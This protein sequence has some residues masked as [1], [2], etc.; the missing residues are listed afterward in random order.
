MIVTNERFVGFLGNLRGWILYIAGLIM[1]GIRAVLC[2]LVPSLRSSNGILYVVK[3]E[4]GVFYAMQ[5]ARLLTRATTRPIR[6]ASPRRFRRVD[7]EFVFIDV[8]KALFCRWDV[9]IFPHH[10]LGVL[11]DPDIP[12]VYISHGLESGK[13]MEQ[14]TSYT[15]GFKAMGRPGK[16]IYSQMIATHAQETKIARESH[17]AFARVTC[18]ST[19]ATAEELLARIPRA[20]AIRQSLGV[21][22][23]RKV[24]LFMSTWGA[25]SLLGKHGHD[26][27]TLVPELAKHFNLYLTYHP[28]L[29]ELQGFDGLLRDLE[30]AGMQI[31]PTGSWLD[32]MVISDL[33]VSDCTSLAFYY[34]LLEKP[35]LFLGYSERRLVEAGLFRDLV[36]FDRSIQSP[37]E[38]IRKI[39]ECLR[40]PSSPRSFKAHFPFLG[41]PTHLVRTI[42]DLHPQM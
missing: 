16:P 6:I 19:E 37:S 14:G 21:T 32:P 31:V 28:K 7:S 25:D 18:L 27:L 8:W 30:K 3:G 40:H 35:I 34:A 4:L 2:T 10:F 13:R 15:Y 5:N 39:S 26:L 23:Q 1:R 38:L 42:L 29:F 41:N 22:D 24:I 33:A 36:T 17:A 20:E 11:F 9:I 12:K